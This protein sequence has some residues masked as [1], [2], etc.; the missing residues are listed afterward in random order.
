MVE[1]NEIV[2]NENL[3]QQWRT[4]MN[5]RNKKKETNKQW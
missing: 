2:G 4:E 5:N 1:G 3:Y